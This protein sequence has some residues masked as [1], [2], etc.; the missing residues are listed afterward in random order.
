MKK[1]SKTKGQH[2]H[3]KRVNKT[4]NTSGGRNR[5]IQARARRKAH[6]LLQKQLPK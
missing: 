6:R 3:A 2:R 4:G 5:T 1:P